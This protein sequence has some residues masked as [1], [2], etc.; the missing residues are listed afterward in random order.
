MPGPGVDRVAHVLVPP[1][2]RSWALYSGLAGLA[3]KRLAGRS[4][5]RPSNRNTQANVLIPDLKLIRN[6]DVRGVVQAMLA[7]NRLSPW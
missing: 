6:C 4:S 7:G 3:N 2:Q 1:H 5:R